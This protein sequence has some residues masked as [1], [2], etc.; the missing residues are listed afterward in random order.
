LAACGTPK[1]G[2][3]KK[4]VEGELGGIEKGERKEALV[5][6][7]WVS[8]KAREHKIF[9]IWIVLGWMNRAWTFSHVVTSG[10]LWGGRPELLRQRSCLRN[11]RSDHKRI[12]LKS[13]KKKLK[14]PRRKGGSLGEKKRN[15]RL[16]GNCLTKGES[17]GWG[18][19][20][21]KY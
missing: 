16:G 6:P 8:E 20:S 15:E 19:G 1:S 12:T 13:L 18:P 2:R 10:G 14:R 3:A 17:G 21:N 11:R 5:M 4:T 9:Q 7:A